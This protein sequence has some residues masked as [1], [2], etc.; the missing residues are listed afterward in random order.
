MLYSALPRLPHCELSLHSWEEI[1]VFL[2]L[3]ILSFLLLPPHSLMKWFTSRRRHSS[4]YYNLRKDMLFSWLERRGLRWARERRTRWLI[5]FP[6]L[7]IEFS[8]DS[9]DV[10]VPQP[11]RQHTME[12]SDDSKERQCR[13]VEKTFSEPK[14]SGFVGPPERNCSDETQTVRLVG[15]LWD[16]RGPKLTHR[17]EREKQFKATIIIII[18]DGEKSTARHDFNRHTTTATQSPP[19]REL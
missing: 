7:L 17:R 13:T 1:N 6:L 15:L 5:T 2:L 12:V 10:P 14:K 16:V 4:I 8:F 18:M 11:T 3:F 9:M 19:H